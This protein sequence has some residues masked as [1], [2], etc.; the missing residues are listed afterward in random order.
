M[1][2]IYKFSCQAIKSGRTVLIYKGVT[3]KTAKHVTSTN[4]L[5]MRDGVMYCDG[6]SCKGMT[7]CLKP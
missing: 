2:R 7:I 5:S 1:D 6:I 4:R 3:A